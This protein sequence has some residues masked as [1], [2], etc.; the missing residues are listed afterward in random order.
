M[1]ICI[2]ARSLLERKWGGVSWYATEMTRAI[3]QC[4]LSASCDIRLFVSGRNDQAFEN[5]KRNAPWLAQEG[6]LCRTHLPN[7]L[8]HMLLVGCNAPQIDMLAFRN[9][10]PDITWLPNWNISATS[11]PYVLTIH[12]L[13][14]FHYPEAYSW[15]ERMWH[16]LVRIRKMIANAHHII[17][18]SEF[19]A[20]DMIRMFDVPES[21]ITIIH[22]GVDERFFT[23]PSEKHKRYIQKKYHLPPA[24]ILGFYGNARKNI[25]LLSSIRHNLPLPLILIG[26]S[27]LP[28][29]QEQDKP[30]VYA[31]ADCLVYPSLF[32]GFGLPILEAMAGGTP[33]IASNTT[34]I[35]EVV[36]NAGLLISP[37]QPLQWLKAIQELHN[38]TALRNELMCKGTERARQFTWERAAREWWEC[39]QI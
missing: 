34:S 13:S 36:D 19:T 39:M 3:L 8:L 35:P 1:N 12:D 4:P 31:L 14:I 23:P 2:D 22:E 38:D 20:H 16:A 30:G 6:T 27:D 25:T 28:F 37:Y 17:A 18:V 9:A 15:K 26:S 32:E 33:V 10:K 11:S 5:I 21:K 24:F 7:I 29:V